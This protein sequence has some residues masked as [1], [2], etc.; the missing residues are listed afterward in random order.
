MSQWYSELYIAEGLWTARSA[1]H[2]GG[3]EDAAL[4]DVDMRLL[5]DENNSFFVPAGSIAGAARSF[6]ARRNAAQPDYERG[7]DGESAA[8]NLMF[9]SSSGFA[10][11]LSVDDAAAEKKLLVPSIRDGVRIDPSSGTAYIS[12]EGGAKYDCE[13]L[14]AGSAFRFALQLKI[15][16]W[17]TIPGG[18][19]PGHDQLLALFRSLL[20]G[21]S[22]A[23]I[24]LGARTRRGWGLGAVDSWNIRCCRLQDR[25]HFVS[26]LQR[27]PKPGASV[28]VRD[29][30]ALQVPDQRRRFTICVS[31][32]LK[33]SIMVRSAGKTEGDPDAVHLTELDR[34]I[35]P[36]TSL[37]GVLRH[38]CRRIART[39]CPQDADD[40][41]DGMFG[42][43]HK[44]GSRESL[45]SSRVW[46]EETLLRDG[47]LHV[48]TRV[49]ID[50]FTQGSLDE[51]LFEEAPFWPSSS[52]EGHVQNLKI[53]LD[54]PRTSEQGGER[55]FQR[56]I[57]LLMMAFKDL[58]LGDLSLGG[59]AGVG[60]GVFHGIRASFEH[61]DFQNALTLAAKSGDDPSLVERGGA[62]ED[63][64]KL[65]TWAGN[66][67]QTEV[68]A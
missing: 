23:E 28:S 24:R 29:L 63:W 59:G 7:I 35:L 37:A 26:W 1:L 62:A 4:S 53:A 22:N 64:L 65:E 68:T 33:T 32:R 9:G 10:S 15:P 8:L 3:G 42:P 46:V 14:P 67:M 16:R 25:E 30:P 56:E 57:A 11:L 61:A 54:F 39:L 2:L 17:E 49:A 40:L 20:E 44:S 45:L 36:G 52:V 27:D 66:W 31:L 43:H 12:E 5:R 47:S 18:A 13:V 50:R 19:A 41:V 60:R 38:R 21:F 34:S 55:R 6:L 48:Q 51:K 58:W